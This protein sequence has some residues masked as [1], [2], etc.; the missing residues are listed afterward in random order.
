MPLEKNELNNIDVEDFTEVA[1]NKRG[2]LNTKLCT[3]F[4]NII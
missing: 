3:D 2:L 1:K 4:L